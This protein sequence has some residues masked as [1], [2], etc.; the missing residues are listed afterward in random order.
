[1]F[2]VFFLGAQQDLKLIIIPSIICLVFRL[3]FIKIYGPQRDSGEYGKKVRECLRFGFLWGLDFHAY[4]YLVSLVFITLPGVFFSE[5]RMYAGILRILLVAVYALCLYVVFMGKMIF[6]GEFHDIYNQTMLLGKHADKGNFFDIF[7]FQ[8]HGG[9]MVLGLIPYLGVTAGFTQFLL[10]T[11]VFPYPQWFMPGMSYAVNTAFFVIAVLLFYYIRYGGHL[12][13]LFKP[14]RNN[15]PTILK[16]DIFFS[17]AVVDDCIA[18]E[19]VLKQQEQRILNHSEEEAVKIMAPVVRVRETKDIWR[20]FLRQAEG[21]RIRKPK[22]IYFIVGES[23]TQVPFDDHYQ[24][25]H[26]VEEGKKFRASAHTFSIPNFLSAGMIS[27]PSLASLFSGIFDANFEINEMPAFQQQQ[28]PTAFAGQVKKLGYTTAYWYGGNTAWASLGRFGKAQGFDICKGAPEFCPPYSPTT[29]LGIYDHIFFEGLYKELCA[30][31][32]DEPMFHL[33]YTTSNH[34]PYTIPVEKYGFDPD[35]IMP[36]LTPDIRKNRK[37]LNNLG[38]YWYA[39]YYMS[40]FIRKV[41][42]LDPDSFI[43]VTG[44]HSRLIIP[45]HTQM[46]SEKEPSVREKYCTSFAMHHPDLQRS[47]FPQ[48]HIGGHMNIMPTVLEAIAPKGFSYYSLVPSFFDCLDRVVTPFHWLTQE[49]VGYYGDE[50]AEALDTYRPEI[51]QGTTC[52]SNERAAWCEFTA[53]IIRHP[54]LWRH[55]GD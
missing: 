35:R 31:P 3:A 16:N 36:D 15:M 8:Y 12:S 21:P 7:F 17:K 51:Q 49:R 33:I 40:E 9:W 24:A 29:W 54:E 44:D 6:Y 14:S 52:F 2:E 38:M 53:W 37:L 4:V 43:L 34:P 32:A 5:Y 39:D 30:L 45:F 42:A 11:P 50:V 23:Y 20:P 25:L 55:V 46:Y 47:M 26:L 13:H 18:I 28:L 27:Q 48:L 10:Q 19:L 41:Q 1:M 22:H